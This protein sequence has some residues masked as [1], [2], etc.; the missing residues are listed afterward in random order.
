MVSSL[1]KHVGIDRIGCWHISD[2]KGARGS[3]IDRHAHI[4]E[5]EIGIVPFGMLA[6]DARFENT[7]VILETPKDGVGD[8]GNLAILRKLRGS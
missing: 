7:P 6:A 5:G 2:N 8:E 4:G 1:S 3:R